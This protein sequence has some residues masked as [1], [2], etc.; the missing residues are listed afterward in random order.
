M[1]GFIEIISRI[2]L[3]I[4]HNNGSDPRNLPLDLFS[5]SNESKIEAFSFLLRYMD[6]TNGKKKLNAPFLKRGGVCVRKFIY[7]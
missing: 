7:K 3:M 4:S 2:A 5:T 6:N 1:R